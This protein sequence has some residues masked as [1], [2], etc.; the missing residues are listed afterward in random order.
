[1]KNMM[2]KFLAMFAAL[3]IMM[4]VVMPVFGNDDNAVAPCWEE[5][6]ND[7]IRD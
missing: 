7:S 4:T 2:K 3:A 1:M 5:W 6:D